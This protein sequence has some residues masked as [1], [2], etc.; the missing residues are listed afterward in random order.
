MKKNIVEKF[1]L[2]W[3]EFEG[4]KTKLNRNWK[5]DLIKKVGE[6]ADIKDSNRIINWIKRGHI[7]K[8]RMEY[9]VNLN[10]PIELKEL[11]E[12]CEKI[13]P[14]TPSEATESTISD[15]PIE[16]QREA[17]RTLIFGLLEDEGI[18]KKIHEL[19]EDEKESK[20]L[21]EELEDIKK[22]IIDLEDR[23]IK[24]R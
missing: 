24:K 9:F 11:C 21:K 22:R 10:M 19:F 17:A 15:N 16:I 2:A 20:I 8:H 18:K 23:A 4:V 13:P 5:S 12:L 7:P 3:A 6:K 1:F 14:E